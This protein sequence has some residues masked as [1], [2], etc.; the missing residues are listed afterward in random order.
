MGTKISALPAAASALGTD[1]HPV[2]QGGVT[3]RETNAQVLAY[4]HADP[5]V[6][7]RIAPTIFGQQYNNPDPRPM[8]VVIEL[9]IAYDHLNPGVYQIDIFTDATTPT[10]LSTFAFQ[11][12]A[13]DDQSIFGAIT[14]VVGQGGWFRIDNVV[15]PGG[16]NSLV[17]IF[18]FLI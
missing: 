11:G 14:I 18:K 5:V 13:I 16:G 8:I 2:N 9:S 10:P 4:I 6:V 1:Q 15:D 12:G 7:T 17:S 3:R